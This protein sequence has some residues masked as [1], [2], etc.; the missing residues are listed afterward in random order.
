MPQLV[1]WCSR[2]VC[3]LGEGSAS[4][5]WCCF[6]ASFVPA[7]SDVDDEERAVDGCRWFWAALFGARAWFFLSSGVGVLFVLFSHACRI[8][9]LFRHSLVR[10]PP[11]RTSRVGCFLLVVVRLPTGCLRFGARRSAQASG[12]MTVRPQHGQVG[13]RA[14]RHKRVE[15]P[16]R[17]GRGHRPLRLGR[18]G[19]AGLA[20]CKVSVLDAR[21]KGAPQ[22]T[23]THTSAQSHGA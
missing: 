10:P 23:R 5:P 22:C 11:L 9:R 1:G 18:C 21:K 8:T 2:F 19:A 7:F 3:F 4:F 15:A 17:F 16:W 12:S 14:R 6:P 13:G 20:S